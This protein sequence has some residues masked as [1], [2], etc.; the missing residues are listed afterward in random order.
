MIAKR[1]LLTLCST[2]ILT[3]SMLPVLDASA[4]E[5]RRVRCE[6]RGDRSKVDVDARGAA[7]GTAH[8]V[9]ITSGGN[10]ATQTQNED[11][12]ELDFRFDSNIEDENNL[13]SD[14]I[15]GDVTAS[16]PGATAKT[17]KCRIR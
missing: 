5:I 7:A 11:D 3:G 2:M 15:Q 14:F 17:A 4:L 10:T 6:A 1:V 9:T 8:T 12:G 13:P 16:I